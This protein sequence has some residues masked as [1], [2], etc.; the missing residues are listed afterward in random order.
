MYRCVC[1]RVCVDPLEWQQALFLTADPP[2]QPPMWTLLTSTNLKRFDLFIRRGVCMMGQEFSYHSAWIGEQR[3]SQFPLSTLK[4]G[5][6][7]LT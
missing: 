7:Y 3:W 5:P 4:E 6:M 2:L 1:A